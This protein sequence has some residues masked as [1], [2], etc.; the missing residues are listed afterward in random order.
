LG[1]LGAIGNWF[2]RMLLLVQLRIAE[3]PGGKKAGKNQK[4]WGKL[5]G[6]KILTK[7][8]ANPGKIE[9]E[10]KELLLAKQTNGQKKKR[11][12]WKKTA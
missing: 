9:T 11:K 7:G 1:F 3:R 8:G 10:P 4:K 12:Q 2:L 5:A 6:T